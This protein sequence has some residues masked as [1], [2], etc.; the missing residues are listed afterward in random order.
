MFCFPNGVLLSEEMIQ[1]QNFSFIQTNGDGDRMY[2][3]CL[4]F[5]E[6]ISVDLYSIIGLNQSQIRHL[7][8]Q[9]KVYYQQKAICLISNYFYIE[10]FQ[11]ILSELYR[12][13]LS[14][15]ILPIER[16]VCN[17]VNEIYYP[18]LTDIGKIGIQF[19]IGSGQ[20]FFKESQN[21]PN[22]SDKALEILFRILDSEKIITL[23]ECVL[24]ERKII[25]I[26]TNYQLNMLV[27][28]ALL[29]LIYPFV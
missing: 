15:S 25:L 3:A 22:I 2:A 10:Q 24:L 8:K 19:S 28:E 4:I 20:I 23:F 27:T 9:N 26:S 5:S 21:Y 17:I 16:Y 11:Q 1:P 18:T 6:P 13:S 7:Q 12:I 14:Q 29:G